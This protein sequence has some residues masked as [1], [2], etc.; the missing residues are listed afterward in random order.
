MHDLT[1]YSEKLETHTQTV[2]NDHAEIIS[3]IFSVRVEH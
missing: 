3:L 2:K 1:S